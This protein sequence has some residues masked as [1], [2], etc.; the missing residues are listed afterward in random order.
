MLISETHLELR[1][2][3]DR[4]IQQAAGYF[5][6]FEVSSNFAGFNFESGELYRSPFDDRA[7]TVIT[8]GVQER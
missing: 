8:A 3:L 5:Q 6:K 4:S 1:I 2:L 7:N